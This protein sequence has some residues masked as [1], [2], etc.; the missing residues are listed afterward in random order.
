MTD[1]GELS[2]IVKTSGCLVAAAGAIGLGWRG[3]ANWEPSEIDIPNAPQ[4][5]AG[6]VCTVAIGVLWAT[7]GPADAA[8]VATLA[9]KL[10]LGTVVFLSLYGYLIAL[11]TYTKEVVRNAGSGVVSEEK[12]IGGFWLTEGAKSAIEQ[13]RLTV[14]RY[15]KKVSYDVDEVWSKGARALAKTLFVIVYIGLVA[16]GTIALAATSIRVGMKQGADVLTLEEEKV[17]ALA[18]LVDTEVL[19]P[20]GRIIE[21]PAKVADAVASRGGQLAKDLLGIDRAALGYGYEL[22]QLEKATQAL[23]AAADSVL[24]STPV[25]ANDEVRSAQHKKERS[26]AYAVAAVSTAG[27]FEDTLAKL[28]ARE[29]TPET[30]DLLAWLEVT[31]HVVDRVRYYHAIALA[32]QERQGNEVK[33]ELLR[34][35]NLIDKSYITDEGDNVLLRGS[36]V[37]PGSESKSGKQV[38]SGEGE[39][40]DEK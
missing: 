11:Q 14:Q 9:M 25:F 3:R 15:F 13:G 24:H 23:V 31:D 40:G 33:N 36:S 21:A 5:V 1:F 34:V 22:Y 28:R 19:E 16:S 27:A 8:W 6:L 10:A 32:I 12:I 37:N 4:R 30:K 29:Q 39:T 2:G 35:W 26:L 7:T 18:H 38:G 17:K 20:W